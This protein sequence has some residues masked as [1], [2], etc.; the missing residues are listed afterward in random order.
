M[1]LTTFARAE[2]AYLTPPDP[3]TL[4]TPSKPVG[5]QCADDCPDRTTCAFCDLPVCTTHEGSDETHET[6]QGTAHH[7]CHR[8][9]CKERECW[10]DPDA[11]YDARFE[12]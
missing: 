6:C 8:Q 4:D 3:I 10:E 1:S 11:A 12:D 9:A 2:R 7:D 5:D